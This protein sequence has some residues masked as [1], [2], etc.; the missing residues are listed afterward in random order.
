VSKE[1]LCATDEADRGYGKGESDSERSLP[2]SV[3]GDNQAMQFDE[4]Y[5]DHI[6]GTIH[7]HDYTEDS[8]NYLIAQYGV[9]RILDVGC[10]CGFLVKTLREKGCDAY[11]IDISDYALANTCASGFVTKGDIRSIPYTDNAFDVVHVNGVMG[12][13][14]IEDT[15]KAIAECKR[16]APQQFFNIDYAPQPDEYGFVFMMPKE[17]WDERL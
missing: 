15:D 8:A 16:V 14:P 4:A 7:R 9:C 3:S 11:G 12:Y 13:F 1:R 2:P 6:W 17:W 5:Y 10:G